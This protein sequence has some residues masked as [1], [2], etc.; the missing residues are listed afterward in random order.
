M[1][2]MWP[3]GQWSSNMGLMHDN[4]PPFACRIGFQAAPSCFRQ[5]LVKGFCSLFL[6]FLLLAPKLA[7]VAGEFLLLSQVPLWAV[8]IPRILVSSLVCPGLHS[9]VDC[10]SPVCHQ[11]A[12]LDAARGSR[13][14]SR[15]KPP[16][17]DRLLPLLSLWV[18]GLMFLAHFYLFL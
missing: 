3:W 15:I 7:T 11:P 1:H 12:V 18:F 8:L 17:K 13:C 14:G 10:V 9:A 16:A 4:P 5:I 2:P 6:P